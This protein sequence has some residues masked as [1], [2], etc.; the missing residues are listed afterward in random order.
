[1]CG[2][3]VECQR[4]FDALKCL[5]MEGPLLVF[6]DFSKD[7]QLETDASGEGLGAVLAQRRDDGSV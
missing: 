4:A 2:L 6:P 3:I 5:L 7:F 1:M